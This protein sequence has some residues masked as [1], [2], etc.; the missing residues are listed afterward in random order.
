MITDKLCFRLMALLLV[1]ALAINP[2]FAQSKK[3]VEA[4]LRVTVVDPNG[5]AIPTARIVIS[6]QAQQ[7]Q[8]GSR[9]EATF[10]QLAAGKVQIEVYADGFA[11]RIYKDFNLRAGAN[12]L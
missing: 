9:G 2:A 10:A 12:Q 7:V 1:T 4:S 11:P 3:S 6:K 8:T 5:E